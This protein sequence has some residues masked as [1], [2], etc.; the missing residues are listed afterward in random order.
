MLYLVLKRLHLKKYQYQPLIQNHSGDFQ[1]SSA[2]VNGI[3]T[4]FVQQGRPTILVLLNRLKS[5]VTPMLLHP[6]YGVE[7][8]IKRK[9][10]VPQYTFTGQ[11]FDINHQ[12]ATA[13]LR[14]QQL[15][16]EHKP[17]CFCSSKSCKKIHHII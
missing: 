12:I 8:P 17:Y 11:Y 4:E 16:K 7:S 9:L 1:W 14:P 2:Y 15:A 6:S 5:K 3:A 10:T 13:L